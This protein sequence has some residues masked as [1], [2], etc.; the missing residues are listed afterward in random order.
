MDCGLHPDA[1]VLQLTNSLTIEGWVRPRTS[2]F[3]VWG[4]GW[5]IFAREDENHVPYYLS[6]EGNNVICFGIGDGSN[7]FGHHLHAARL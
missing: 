7:N 5:T 2:S 6:M 4:A 1:P 3:W